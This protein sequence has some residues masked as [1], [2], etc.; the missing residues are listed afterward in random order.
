MANR[1][2]AEELEKSRPA[3]SSSGRGG[4][5]C[6]TERIDMAPRPLDPDQCDQTTQE[7]LSQSVLNVTYVD[8][9]HDRVD[10]IDP[11]FTPST[12][13]DVLRLAGR[14]TTTVTGAGASDQ[15]QRESGGPARE[16]VT[17]QLQDHSGHWL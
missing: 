5:V 17:S 9:V 2:L 12:T 6:G 13:S 8:V 16:A 11:K 4:G 1:T 14:Q 3:L 7:E 10:I 15:V